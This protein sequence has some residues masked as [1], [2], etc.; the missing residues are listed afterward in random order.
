MGGYRYQPKLNSGG[1]GPRTAKRFQAGLAAATPRRTPI[2]CTRTYLVLTSQPSSRPRRHLTLALSNHSVLHERLYS[3]LL[4]TLFQW[5]RAPLPLPP[6]IPHHHL[7]TSSR[8]DLPYHACNPPPPPPPPPPNLLFSSPAGGRRRGAGQAGPDPAAA[9]AVAQHVRGAAGRRH[10]RRAARRVPRARLR[11]H[12]QVVRRR[13]GS[14]GV[15]AAGIE[16]GR[17]GGVV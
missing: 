9:L 15:K 16:G 17:G 3:P 14:R 8:L 12:L 1:R 4:L 5:A 6:P 11:P 10:A 2:T 13:R 7:P